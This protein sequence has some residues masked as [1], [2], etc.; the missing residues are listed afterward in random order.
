[1]DVKGYRTRFKSTDN[2]FMHWMV[3]MGTIMTGFTKATCTGEYKLIGYAAYE[4]W[5]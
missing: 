1:M 5:A 4:I 3:N 2:S